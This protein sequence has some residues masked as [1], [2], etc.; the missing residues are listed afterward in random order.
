MSDPQVFR[1]AMAILRQV[2]P[3]RFPMEEEAAQAVLF[4]RSCRGVHPQAV[5]QAAEDLA[6]SLEYAPTPAAFGK[7]ARKLHLQMFPSIP[8]E[9][10][11]IVTTAPEEVEDALQEITKRIDRLNARAHWVWQKVG[12]DKQKAH[13]FWALA[14]KHGSPAEIWQYQHG[15]CSKEQLRSIWMRYESGHRAGDATPVPTP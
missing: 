3:R 10:P 2:W 7:L 12:R 15:H 11:V 13:D 1:R 6:T 9:A 14:W 5:A 8:L 4:S